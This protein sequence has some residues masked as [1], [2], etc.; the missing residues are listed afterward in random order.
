MRST[1]ATAAVERLNT[2]SGVRQY[3]MLKTADDR[4]LLA[5]RE[6]GQP[7][8]KLCEA[9]ELDAFVVFV[10]GCGP[11]AVRRVTKNDVAFEKQL[12]PKSTSKP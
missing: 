4:F 9:L 12:S 1:R 2:R 8:E 7:S 10:N 11:Q 5:R 6:A 3:T